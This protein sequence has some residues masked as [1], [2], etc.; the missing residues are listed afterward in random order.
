MTGRTDWPP[1]K[2]LQKTVEARL[3][4]MGGEVVPRRSQSFSSFIPQPLT[5]ESWH[6]VESVSSVGLVLSV[7]TLGLL[8]RQY[9]VTVS[10]LLTDRTE[11]NSVTL[12]KSQKNFYSASLTLTKSGKRPVLQSRNPPGGRDRA[13]CD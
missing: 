7:G 2:S 1:L 6:S 13:S 3:S 11:Q 5:A 9:S 10:V 4:R 8:A 12:R